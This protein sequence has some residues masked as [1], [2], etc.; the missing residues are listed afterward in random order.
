METSEVEA[1]T[2]ETGVQVVMCDVRL[3]V[4]P[5]SGGSGGGG[6]VGGRRC[7]AD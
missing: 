1:Q 7:A 4:S 2:D 6:G 5:P 3:L